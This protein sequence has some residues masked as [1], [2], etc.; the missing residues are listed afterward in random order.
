MTDRSSTLP[1][2]TAAELGVRPEAIEA[3]AAALDRSGVEVHGLAVV[4]R[5]YLV[6]LGAWSPW[7]QQRPTLAYSVSKALTASCVGIAIGDGLLNLDDRLVDLLGERIGAPVAPGIERITVA[8]LLAMA[9]GHIAD[10]LPAMAWHDDPLQAFCS[11][12]PAEEPG[13]VFCYNNGATWLLGELVRHLSG[14]RLV[15]FAT[16]R[17]LAPLGITDLHWQESFGKELGFSGC[18]LTVEQIAAIAELYRCDGVWQGDRLLPEGWVQHAS[19]TQI[20]TLGQ[21]NEHSSLGYGYQL[22]RHPGG[23]R[24]DGAFAQYGI[25]LPE[26]EAVIAVTSGSFPSAGVMEAVLIHLQPGLAPLTGAPVRPGEPDRIGGLAVPWPAGG[27]P[28]RTVQTHGPV[29]GERPIEAEEE[30]WFPE[31]A[32]AAVVERHG[33][34]HLQLTLAG[35]PTGVDL[36]TSDWLHGELAAEDG[37]PVPV[38]ARCHRADDTTTVSLAFIDTPHRLS[39]TLTEEGAVQRW[40]CPPLNG[41]PLAGLAVDHHTLTPDAS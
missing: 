29:R 13:S 25:V 3:F 30:W 36:G 19:S 7:Q 16:R 33:G 1:T 18:F 39:L 12:P 41:A 8:H 37:D 23:Y 2:A 26:Q 34:W 28:V 4:R 9:T 31:L 11:Q 5:G 32:D 24:L 27:D 20:S 40:N 22:W 35:R 10:T 21:Q 15:D 14:E 38:A 6:Q 17:F